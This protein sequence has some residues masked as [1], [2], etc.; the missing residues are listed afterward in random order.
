MPVCVLFGAL[1][2]YQ[3]AGLVAAL[4]LVAAARW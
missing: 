3:D 4:V 2:W 1:Y